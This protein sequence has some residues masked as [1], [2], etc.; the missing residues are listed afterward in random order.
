M[1]TIDCIKS[2]RSIRKFLPN[3]IPE[4]VLYEI[5][6]AANAAPCAGNLQCWRFLIIEKEDAKKVIAKSALDQDWIATAPVVVIVLSDSKALRE[7]YGERGE[8]CYD[9]QNAALATENLMLAAW[10]FGIGSTFVGAFTEAKLRKEFR[11]PDSMKI[12]AVIPLGYPSEMP[13]PLGKI[14][15][16]DL[17]HIEHWGRE[18]SLAREEKEGLIYPKVEAPRIAEKFEEKA[19]TQAKRVKKI[20][21]SKLK[22]KQKKQ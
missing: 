1:D 16:H 3:K 2:R 8:K 11:I 20:L 9:A 18:V 13:R 22:K 5:L 4:P 12:H 14:D 10:N 15:M 21:A 17:T 7:E 19:K 6:D